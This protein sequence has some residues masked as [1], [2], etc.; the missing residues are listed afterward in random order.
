MN[1][2]AGHIVR[3]ID[4]EQEHEKFKILASFRYNVA[5]ELFYFFGYKKKR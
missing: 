5:P 4:E 2:F 3:F 1:L